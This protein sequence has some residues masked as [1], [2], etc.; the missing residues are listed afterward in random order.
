MMLHILR[1]KFI[2]L[3]RDEEG[4]AMVVTLA[5]F[6]LMYLICMGVYAIGTAVKTRIHLQNACDAAAYSAAVVQA[7]TLSRIA[8]LNRAMSWTYVAMTRRQMDVITYRWLEETGRHWDDDKRR[9]ED[10]ANSLIHPTPAVCSLAA[11]P[12]GGHLKT[13]HSFAIP[14]MPM[15]TLYGAIGSN[16]TTRH[17]ISTHNSLFTTTHVGRDSSFYSSKSSGI[18]SMVAQIK[19]DWENVK[20]MSKAIDDL[21]KHYKEQA[22]AAAEA[23]LNANLVDVGGR[24][25]S[26]SA[27]RYVYMEPMTEYMEELENTAEEEDRFLSYCRQSAKSAFGNSGEVW[28]I[29]NP[30]TALGFSRKYDWGG[31]RLKAT[32]S[33][34]SNQWH[35]E[36]DPLSGEKHIGPI[37]CPSCS[38][39]SHSR[40]SCSGFGVFFATVYG[41]NDRSVSGYEDIYETPSRYVARP[42]KLKKNYFG[43]SG[44]NKGTITVGLAVENQNPWTSILGKTI[45]G[46]FSAFNIGGDVF[47][48]YTVCFASAKAGYK[49]TLNW[50]NSQAVEDDRAYRVDW[51]NE[52]DWNLR[53]S[54]WDAVLIPVRRAE[55][56]AVGGKWSD[57]NMNF[58]DGYANELGVDSTEMRAGGDGLD[59]DSFYGARNLGEEYRFGNQSGFWGGADLPIE[60]EPDAVKAKW[61]IGN[62]HHPVDWNAMQKVMLH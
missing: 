36:T 16:P 20:A 32:W 14:E 29:R 1:D 62:P 48:L 59:I 42:N 21:K 50:E 12:V 61:Q 15:I 11:L 44:G 23:V 9:A 8:T 2:R 45:K 27:V 30:S 18:G 22:E 10:W 54:D 56:L 37:P 5:I 40:C 24:D 4:V 57:G 25:V 26:A 52:K 39:V 28:F 60:Q 43:E 35:C 53:Q 31:D 34:Y 46:I 58:L 55:S 7:D 38:H 17:I 47:P 41:D 3:G 6:M 49:E 51:Q 33:W 13:D 19:D